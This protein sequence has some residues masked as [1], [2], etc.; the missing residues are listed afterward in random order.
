M[1]LP[2][3]R[4]CGKTDPRKMFGLMTHWFGPLI[5]LPA[6]S[7][8]FHLCPR[9]YEAHIQPHLEAMQGRLAELHP[10]VSGTPDVSA[11]NG[12]GDA[13]PAGPAERARAAD[14][15]ARRSMHRGESGS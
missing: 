2:A 1:A 4:R 3:C 11:G 6:G 9:C 13:A 14:E 15:A 12:A 5:D 8:Y 7:G 10:L